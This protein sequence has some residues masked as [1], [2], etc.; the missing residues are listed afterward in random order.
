MIRALVIWT[1]LL[2]GI[3]TAFAI[4]QRLDA[5]ESDSVRV[6]AGI[7]SI[8]GWPAIHAAGVTSIMIEA[9]K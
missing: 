1:W 9:D 8:V 4:N 2:I 7:I 6:W 3:G 5:D